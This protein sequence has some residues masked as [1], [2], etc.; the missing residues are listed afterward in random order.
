[1]EN[2]HLSLSTQ[3]NTT[4]QPIPTTQPNSQD[5]PTF[6]PLWFKRERASFCFRQLAFLPCLLIRMESREKG[7]AARPSSKEKFEDQDPLSLPTIVLSGTNDASA[8]STFFLFL[9]FFSLFFS[10]LPCRLMCQ[11]SDSPATNE[12]STKAQKTTP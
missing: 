3:H 10:N 5:S 9:G 12:Q 11:Q 8:E 6:A 1:M 7:K 2:S 4:S